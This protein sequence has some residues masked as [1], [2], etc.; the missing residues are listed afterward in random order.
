MPALPDAF[1]SAPIAHR[2]LHGP[3]KPENSLAAAQAAIDA[4]YGIELDIQP[5]SDGTPMVFHDYRLKRLV[6]QDGVIGQYDVEAL[7]AMRILGSDQGVPTLAEFLELV[8]GKVPLLVEIK[9]QDGHLGAN[10][11]TLH[12]KVVEV[13][14]GYDGPVAVMSFN[15]H[16]VE[17]VHALRPGLPVG[18]TTC[19]FPAE[20]WP[21]IDDERRVYLAGISDY[22]RSG[23][24][25]ISHDKVELGNPRVDALKAMGAPILCW[26]VRSEA[27]EEAARRIA[28]N[29]TFEGYLPPV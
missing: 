7:A 11:G 3:G 28:D 14:E 26:T 22:D 20:D 18:L 1:L 27:E 24:S 23:A 29:I 19:D 17:A 2:G 8:A 16:V 9:D 4:G 25:F 12:Q 6:G 13:L 21:L 10:I 15:P 5:A